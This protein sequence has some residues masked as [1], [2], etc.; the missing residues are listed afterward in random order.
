M[1]D[2]K[3]TQV[4]NEE[5]KGAEQAPA[6]APAAKEGSAAPAQDHRGRGPRGGGRG[7]GPRGGGRGPRRGGPRG[8]G[9][10]FKPEYEQK[11]IDLRRVARTVAGG[12]RFSFRVGVVIGNRRGA[13]GVGLGKGGDTALAI[14]KAVKNARRNLITVPMTEKKTIP[15]EVHA[16][17]ASAI[18]DIRPAPGKGL[19]A[20][21]SIR[22]VLDLAG[23]TDV[24]A[25]VLSR[26][27]NKLNNARVALE[28][29]KTITPG[30]GVAQLVPEVKTEEAAGEGERRP[31]TR[32]APHQ[33][34]AE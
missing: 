15:H 30:S 34:S 32:R 27:K 17:Y 26:S 28:A 22:S 18:V 2:E 9:E 10:R 29:L 3:D 19:V 7:R 8:T 13:V 11:I 21:S 1:A 31:R 20:G 5:T 6:A 14:E 25:K 23:V 12:R 24:T 33:A 4:K 16:K